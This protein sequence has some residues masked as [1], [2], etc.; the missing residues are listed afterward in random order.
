MADWRDGLTPLT[1]W[2][3][4]L[5]GT[6][7][8]DPKGPIAP[9]TRVRDAMGNLSNV[10]SGAVS[11]GQLGSVGG[12][13]G[14]ATGALLGGAGG[15]LMPPSDTPLTDLG[16][17]AGEVLGG[18]F[19]KGAPESI[20]NIATKTRMGRAASEVIKTGLGAA[21]GAT[22]DKALGFQ[23]ETPWGNVTIYSALATPGAILGSLGAKTTPIASLAEK[24]GIPLSVSEATGLAPGLENMLL[25][26]SNAAKNLGQ[27]QTAAAQS[28]L[29]KIIGSPTENS[30]GI[31]LNNGLEA[32]QA[33][34]ESFGK[35]AEVFSSQRDEVV[36]KKVPS[37]FGWKTVTEKIPGR[38]PNDLDFGKAFGLTPEEVWGF[39]QFINAAPDKVV[40]SLMQRG[41]NQVAGVLPLRA[42]MTML[43]RSGLKNESGQLGAAYAM[44]LLREPFAPGVPVNGAEIAKRIE[45]AL[46]NAK[47]ISAGKFSMAAGEPG[48]LVTALGPERANALREVAEVLKNANPLEKLAGGSNQAKEGG[49]YLFNKIA[50]TMASTSAM[51]AAGGATAPLGS[52]LLGSVGGG[53]IGIGLP[54]LLGMVM[55]DPKTAGFLKQAAKGDT[56][57]VSRILRTLG[58]SAKSESDRGD[59]SLSDYGPSAARDRLRG[60]FVK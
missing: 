27:E 32:R 53:V 24:H 16:A 56:A 13:V 35:W 34:K 7:P 37:G 40:E 47:E 11:G 3:A 45:F 26:G 36:T 33:A 49:S 9:G 14:I 18:L 31:V 2:R 55:A 60:L 25:R 59:L 1:D 41:E 57:A 10:V 51:A 6:A 46:G 54:T 30:L 5:Q 8:V 22:G 42:V 39:K 12:P 23:K 20:R 17:T 21:I 48:P 28:A 15:A 19:L 58:N 50:F 43:D 38:A 52:I 29:T 44:R 4:G